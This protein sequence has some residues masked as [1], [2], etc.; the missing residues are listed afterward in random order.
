M[1]LNV[2]EPDEKITKTVSN[3]EEDDKRLK[4]NDVNVPDLNILNRLY[5]R[6]TVL[7]F[8]EIVNLQI[9]RFCYHDAL[10]IAGNCRMCLIETNKSNKPVVSCATTLVPGLHIYTNSSLIKQAR[11]NVLEFLL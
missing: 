5:H 2:R 1:T 7:K 3:T 6:I 8:C 10:S 4:V 11:E 9:P